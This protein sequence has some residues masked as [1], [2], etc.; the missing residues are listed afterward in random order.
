MRQARI[1]FEFIKL[2]FIYIMGIDIFYSINTFIKSLKSIF[3]KY[4]KMEINNGKNSYL[5]LIKDVKLD[6][7]NT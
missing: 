3:I 4:I 5:D 7:I 2:I 6:M 1:K